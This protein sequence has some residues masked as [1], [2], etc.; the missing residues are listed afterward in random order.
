MDADGVRESL[1]TAFKEARTKGDAD[2]MA[3][4]ALAMPTSQ[5]FGAYPGEIPALL[6]EAYSDALDP[7]TRC[8]LA[9]ALARSW[10]YGGD[11]ARAARFADEA[12]QLSAEIGDPEVTADA[13]EAAL[14]AHWGPDDFA[15]RLSLAARLDEVAAHVQ[16]TNLRLGAHLWRL[17]TA[18]ECLDIVA[19]QRQL[20]A[21]DVVAQES[22]SA[23]AA[24]YAASRRAMYALATDDVHAA[25]QY[26]DQT[27]VIG[28]ELAEADVRSVLHLLDATRMQMTGDV[29]GLREEAAAAE[30]FG[31]GQGIPAVSALSATLWLAAGER[32]RAAKLVLQL[33]PGGIAGT[34]RDVDFL[35][36][37]ACIVDVAAT[38]GLTDIAREG[39]TSLEPYA[40]RG[41]INTGAVTFHGVVDDYIYRA[42]RA[43]ADADQWRHAAQRAYRRIGAG[44]WER[45]LGSSGAPHSPPTRRVLLERDDTGRWTVGYE[46]ATFGL[47]D[48]KGLHYLRS[49]IEQPGADLEAL[50]LSVAVA[51]HPGTELKESDT[52]DVLDESAITAYRRRLAQLD[53]ELDTADARG[54][55]R[56]AQ[57]AVAERDA[58]LDQLRRATGLRGRARRSGASTERARVAVRKAVAAAMA[59]IERHDP[60]L[61]RTL[62][63]SIHTGTT[64]RY[65]PNPDL[66]LAWITR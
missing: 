49:L 64:C 37:V 58:L 36:M 61:A 51:G 21:L 46:G 19:V 15:T 14:V 3:A 65:E 17:T 66:A 57:K 22:G 44:W 26:I 52:G 31:A 11:T 8:R 32:D 38:C 1:V 18:W 10:V 45:A 39:A 40:G 23:R 50:A 42:R 5:A 30:A 41:V 34:T 27:A 59:Q 35:L 43:D 47:A 20:R 33:V 7:A 53:T 2:A 9:A 63:D 6:F 62:R 54:D 16:D 48:L 4:A 24:F 13:F 56:M 12:Q 55:Q 60:S 25:E 28:A 29:D